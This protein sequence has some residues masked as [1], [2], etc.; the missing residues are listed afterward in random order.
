LRCAS[1]LVAGSYS[2][3]CQATN[4][5][6]N[7]GNTATV[8]ASAVS[9]TSIPMSKSDARFASNVNGPN[10]PFSTGTQSNKTWDDNPTYPGGDSVW[11]WRP[12]ASNQV[13]TI[14]KCII[15]TREG[16]R[17]TGWTTRNATFNVDQCYL[18]CVG[19]GLDHAD[20]FQAYSNPAH[21]HIVNVTNSLIH[22]YSTSAAIA[23][24]G[25]DFVESTCF[26]FADWAQGDLTFDN[27]VFISEGGYRSLRIF[28]DTGTTTVRMR[29]CFFTDGTSFDI[30]ATGGTLTILEWMNNRVCTI[31]GNT[32]IPGVT[33]PHP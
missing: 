29:N 19:R 27:C 4:A 12:T 8:T 31:S 15:D 3:T 14:S 11:E 5:A 22:S 13:F 33:I 28:A 32:I 6:G 23:K 17:L 26:F 18:N 16:P 24:Y 7:G 10:G 9:S 30:A 21:F 1:G 25:S 20:A 2:L